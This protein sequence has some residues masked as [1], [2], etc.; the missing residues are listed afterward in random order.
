VLRFKGNLDSNLLELKES[1]AEGSFSFGHFETFII[2]DPKERTI[3][4]APFPE[5]VVHHAIMNVLDPV[6]DGYQIS[7]S[8]ACRRG[9]G[10]QAAVLRAFYCAKNHSHFLKLDVRKYFDSVDHE[11]LRLS[12]RRRIKD[13]T[14]LEILDRI[15]DSYST[16]PGK[17]IPIGNLTSQY[18]ANHY[19][20]MLDHEIVDRLRMGPWIR[21]MDDML[22]LDEDKSRLHDLYTYIGDFCQSD[23]KLAIKPEILD[24]CDRGIPFLGFLVKPS[25]IFLMKRTKDRFRKKYSL[26]M[27]EFESDML[28]EDDFAVRSTALCAHLSIARSRAFRQNAIHGRVLG[29][30][31]RE[32]RRQLEQQC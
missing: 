10:T 1:L 18:F 5:R 13:A 26:L 29:H 19:L 8:Y 4:A 15:V 28:S 3:C 9:K 14:V 32:T 30:E 23:L 20:A 22:C 24:R 16:S 6:L 17:G 21:Y 27:H 2:R 12:L 7:D 11:V 31:P 25:G